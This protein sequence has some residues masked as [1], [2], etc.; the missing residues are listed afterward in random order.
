M[1]KPKFLNLIVTILFVILSGFCTRLVAQDIDSL[2]TVYHNSKGTVQERT[3]EALLKALEAHQYNIDSSYYSATSQSEKRL[4]LV[5]STLDYY[6]KNEQYYQSFITAQYLVEISAP[7]YDTAN[8]ILGYYYM[9]FSCQR[10]GS[11]DKALQYNIICYD[12][13]SAS[14]DLKTLSSVMNNM[15]NVYM[16]NKQLDEAVS[17][18]QRSIEIW[19]RLGLHDKLATPLGNLSTAYLKQE[20]YEEALK[21]ANEALAID[22]EMKRPQKIAIRLNQLGNIY[23]LTHLYDSALS[24]QRKS[25][26]YFEQA[27]SEYG[28]TITLHAIGETYE[29]MNKFSLAIDHYERALLLAK[30]NNNIYL[31]QSICRSLYSIYRDLYPSKALEYYEQYVQCKDSIFND[32]NQKLINNFKVS[33]QTQEKEMKIA[34]QARTIAKN[35]FMVW[36][37]ACGLAFITI[38]LI[39]LSNNLRLKKKRYD[40]LA[41]INEMKDKF[42][43]LFSH[44][45]KNSALSQQTVLHHLKNCLST[46]SYDELSQ[47]IEVVVDS[48]DTQVELLLNLLNWAR[49]QTSRIEFTPITFPIA[50]VVESNIKVFDNQ[51]KDKRISFNINIPANT[52]CYSDR[53]MISAIIRNYISNAMKFSIDGQAIDISLSEKDG[54]WLLSVTDH[55]V[56]ISPQDQDKVFKKNIISSMGTKGETGSS[57]GLSICKDIADIC[58]EDLSFESVLGSGSTFS[59]TITKG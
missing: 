55:G 24:C 28:Q 15:G 31:T 12:L 45:L 58:H 4:I 20:R 36:A 23:L 54:K 34:A 33:Y 37:F 43:S 5:K 27:G 47:S 38:I 2:F 10:S 18:F 44:D 9:G 17:Y 25:H 22:K 7:I 14:G 40:D 46:L 30:K 51:A 19:R 50:E 59:L 32:E 39:L 21:A 48:S 35:R 49:I 6:F 53:N 41:K 42:M 52:I 57:I 16:T 8:L 13:T 11:I 3:G 29:S 56:G 1:L 26:A